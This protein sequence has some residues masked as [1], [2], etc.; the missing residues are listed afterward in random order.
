MAWIK[1]IDYTKA[2]GKLRKIYDKIKGPDNYID[3]IML[4]HSLRPNTLTGHMAVYK[5]TLHHSNNALPKWFLEA[6]GGYVSSLNKCEY[7]VVHHFTGMSR[8]LDDD[9]LSQKIRLAL[10]GD[11]PDVYFVEK[12]LEIMRYVKKLTLSPGIMKEEDVQL[13]KQSGCTD[14][15]IL[16]VNQVVAYFSYANRTALGLGVNTKNEII[17]LSPG[18]VADTEDWQHS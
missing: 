3:N 9:G 13:L 15:E 18:N 7:C 10:E 5:N 11:E 6:I 4:V 8:I 17:G 1:I 16:E 2:E 12:E 14:G